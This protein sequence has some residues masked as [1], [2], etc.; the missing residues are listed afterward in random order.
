MTNEPCYVCGL[1]PQRSG[2]VCSAECE[3][4]VMPSQVFA[5][6]E[7]SGRM[8]AWFQIHADALDYRQHLKDTTDVTY[9]IVAI[10][11]EE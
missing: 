4:S 1:N 5:L 2:G 11:Y 3:A 6:V 7:D 9:E 10:G 8:F